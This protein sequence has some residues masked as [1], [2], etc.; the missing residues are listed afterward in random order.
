MVSVWLVYGGVWLLG[1]LGLLAYSKLSA[2][3]AWAP[4]G[5]PPANVHTGATS[6]GAPALGAPG[7]G[8]DDFSG[9]S[10]PNG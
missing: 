7:R 1:L 4:R 5:S 9:L 6:L 8:T 10:H 2:S 3:D